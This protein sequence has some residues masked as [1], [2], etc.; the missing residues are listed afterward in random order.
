MLGTQLFLF[1]IAL[2]PLLAA[3]QPTN[4]SSLTLSLMA[5]IFGTSFLLLTRPGHEQ[6]TRRLPTTSAKTQETEGLIRPRRVA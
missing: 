1:D 3:I 2:A 5:V 4:P 6:R